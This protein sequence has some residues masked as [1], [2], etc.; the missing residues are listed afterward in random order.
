MSVEYNLIPEG[1][2]ALIQLMT[3]VGYVHYMEF[4]RRFARDLIF[5]KPEVLPQHLVGNISLPILDEDY[6]TLKYDW[7]VLKTF[8]R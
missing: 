6:A 8:H 3:S 2:A 4:N 1:K 7:N 5:V